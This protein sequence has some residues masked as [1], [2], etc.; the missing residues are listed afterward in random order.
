MK[1]LIQRIFFGTLFMLAFAPL[2][3]HAQNDSLVFDRGNILVGEIKEMSKGIITIETDYSDS[4][5]QIEWEKVREFYSDQLYT[6]A[7]NDR[8][9]WTGAKLTTTSP[10]KLKIEAVEGTREANMFDIVYIRQLDETFFSKLYANVDIGYS[11]TKANNLRQYSARAALGYKANRLKIGGTYDQVES[12]Q[13]EADRI[14]RTEIGLTGDYSLRNGIFFGAQLNFL[15]NTEQRLDLRTT[16]VAGARYYIFRTN[17]LYWNVF[18]GAAINNEYF[19]NSG[20]VEDVDPQYTP[21]RTSTEGVVGME[22]NLFDTGDLNLMS[23]VYWFPSFTESGRNRVNARFDLKY[24][25]P[26]DFYVRTGI[27]YNYDSQPANGASTDDYVW[28]S[29]FGWEL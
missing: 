6:L 14:Q 29:G 3:V 1:P 19:D 12:T 2:D 5:F 15:S 26:Y 28:Q 20:F 17:S 9:L 25:L 22:I 8:S 27:T 13:E 11:V 16:A 18:L 7:L 23:N 4:D 21:S 24:D 10:G